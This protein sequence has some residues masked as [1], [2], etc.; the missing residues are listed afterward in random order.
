MKTCFFNAIIYPE[1]SKTKKVEG[2]QVIKL[3]ENIKNYRQQKCMTQSQL[4]VVF[5]VS[6]QAVS[7]WE[8]GN[9]YP[10]IALLPAIADYFGITIDELMGMEC[11][12]DDREIEEII[13][14]VRENERKGLISECIDILKDAARKYPTSYES[15][16]YLVTMLN[17][18]NCEDETKRRANSEKAI[19]ISDRILNECNDKDI[20]DFIYNEKITAL[21]NLG[22]VDEAVK[23]ALNLPTI[24]ETSNNRLQYLLTGADR[25]V[26]L[27]NCVIQF[28]QALYCA[29]ENLSDLS[30]QDE[31]LTIRDRINIAKR[32]LEVLDLCYEGNYGGD[33]RLMARMNRYIAAME[34]LEGNIEDTLVHLEKA[35][36]HAMAFDTLPDEVSLTSTLLKGNTY[37]KSTYLKNYSWTECKELCD[38]LPQ[39]RYDFVRETERF[40]AIERKIAEYVVTM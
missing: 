14:R 12:K 38:R 32:G 28:A 39:E 15:L 35:A 24:W 13:E 9:S 29:I 37:K 8:N 20:C 7:R 40:K 5:S 22:R 16:N 17:F 10:D 11:Y 4:A 19:E 34:A 27:K 30:F 18:E 23:M 33:N 31:S 6:E 2:K 1:A 3:S 25:K 36:E 26:H 21:Q